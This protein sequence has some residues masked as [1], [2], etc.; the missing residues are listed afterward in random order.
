MP[1]KYFKY[2]QGNISA[3]LI[4]SLSYL[5]ATHIIKTL[6]FVTSNLTNQIFPQISEKLLDLYTENYST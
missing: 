6:I 5:L 2:N 4:M 1:P 3:L